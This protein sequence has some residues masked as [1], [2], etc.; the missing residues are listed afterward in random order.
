MYFLDANYGFYYIFN[1]FFFSIC[2]TC[3][4]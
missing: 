2:I 4:N 1:F 3:S